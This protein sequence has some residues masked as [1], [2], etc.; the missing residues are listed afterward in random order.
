MIIIA[1]FGG[2]AA[3]ALLEDTIE[4]AEVV[5]PATVTYLCYRLCAI[6]ELTAGIAQTEV[7]DVVAEVTPRVELEEA[8]KSR[9]AHASDIGYLRQADF[10]AVV[11]VN[12]GPNFL[13]TTAVAGNLYLSKA[14]GGQRTGIELR[15]FVEDRHEL[16][17]GVEDLYE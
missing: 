11:F 17:K 10:V 12:E 1:E 2:T 3:L 7:D 6:D 13:H 9:R 15:E 16:R 8:A 14:A 4:I 5:K